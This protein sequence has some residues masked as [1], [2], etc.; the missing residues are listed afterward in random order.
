[1]K[2]FVLMMVMVSCCYGQSSRLS[3]LQQDV[4]LYLLREAYAASTSPVVK[5]SIRQELRWAIQDARVHVARGQEQL[6]LWD[7]CCSEWK[8]DPRPKT[9]DPR[10]RAQDPGPKT[11][12]PSTTYEPLPTTYHSPPTTYHLPP[13]THHLPPTFLTS[14]HVQS[15]DG[16]V[17]YNASNRYPGFGGMDIYRVDCMHY[18]IINE[19]RWLPPKNLG[20]GINTGADEYDVEP[21]PGGFLFRRL[22]NG[23]EQVYEAT[24]RN[25][26]HAVAMQH[27]C[28]G[29]PVII[30]NVRNCNNVFTTSVGF[31]EGVACPLPIDA[32]KLTFKCCARGVKREFVRC[33]ITVRELSLEDVDIRTHDCREVAATTQST[34]RTRFGICIYETEESGK[35][36]LDAIIDHCL[37]MAFPG[38]TIRIHHAPGH[39]SEAIADVVDLLEAGGIDVDVIETTE[40]RTVIEIA[41][42]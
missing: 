1:M 8:I 23:V 11:Q 39:L 41:G 36:A 24:P 13:T 32:A 27:T 14:S 6:Q 31:E 12:D 30:M 4:E 16:N 28:E 18:S 19:A 29:E 7:L 3:T 2:Q 40:A 20:L 10:P 25:V 17:L 35:R 42:S 33:D 15:E 38:R 26:V 34:G 5:D 9:Q 37:S 22:E 21:T